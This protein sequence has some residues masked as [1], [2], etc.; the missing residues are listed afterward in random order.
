MKNYA[1]L[2]KRYIKNS[3]PLQLGC[4]AA[5]LARINSFSNHPEH[6]EIIKDLLRESEFFIEWSAPECDLDIQT[7]LAK[8]QIQLAMWYNKWS[9]IWTDAVK[10][11]SVSEEV[12]GWSNQILKLAG[13]L[14]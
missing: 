4:L 11:K 12:H 1:N 10:L 8:L 9:E 13:L 2:Y 7:M 6:R 14:K 5:N 3:V